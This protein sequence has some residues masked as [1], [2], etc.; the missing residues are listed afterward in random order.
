MKGDAMS[1][2]LFRSIVK[3]LGKELI[4]QS[5]SKS[6]IGSQEFHIEDFKRL[7]N[8]DSAFQFEVTTWSELSDDPRTTQVLAYPSLVA[9][10]A[11]VVLDSCLSK[12]CAEVNKFN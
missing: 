12:V 8:D 5:K 10:I 6:P 1:D 3:I 4:R 11:K 7:P 9:L 2:K